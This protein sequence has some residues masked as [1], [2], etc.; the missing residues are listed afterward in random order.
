MGSGYRRSA[1][2]AAKIDHSHAFCQLQPRNGRRPVSIPKPQ[3][4]HGVVIGGGAKRAF[5]S[6]HMFNKRLLR[7]HEACPVRAAFW[8]ALA[9]ILKLTRNVSP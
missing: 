3:R 7:F 2:T 5:S 1:G 9:S 6:P 8:A 4:G